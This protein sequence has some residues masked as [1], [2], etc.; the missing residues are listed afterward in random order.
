MRLFFLLSLSLDLFTLNI[1]DLRKSFEEEGPFASGKI[2]TKLNNGLHFL[3]EERDFQTTLLIAIH[4]RATEG[5][6]WV[7]PLI[8]LDNK[9]N[10]LSFYRWNT[11]GCPNEA[12]RLISLEINRLKEKYKKIILIGH[13]YGGLVVSKILTNDFDTK[14]EGHFVASPIKGNFL[15]RT[16]CGYTSPKKINKKNQG[17][18]WMTIKELDGEFKNLKLDPQLFEIEG[19]I[20][21]RL[22]EEYND[23]KLGH[24]WSIS[25]LTDHL[26]SKQ[27]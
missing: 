9:N 1:D 14:I 16:F 24:N 6:E 20:A 11:F 17:F 21:K 3:E 27:E 12:T 22:P 26:N 10:R 13:S 5:Y 7:Y 15:L 18:N 25:W 4:G 2:L 23:N 19:V 8:N